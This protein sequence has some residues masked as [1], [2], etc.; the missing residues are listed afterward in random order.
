VDLIKS[1]PNFL[2]IGAAK[3]GT[4]SLFDLL[5]Q[6]PQIY[7]PFSK[8]PMYFSNDANFQRGP[9]W[10][11]RTFF[12]GA[13]GYPARG[14]ATPHY[15]YWSDKVAPRIKQFYRQ[16][17]IRFIVILRDPVAR[18]Y[19]WYWN[20]V[21]EGREDLPFKTA[22]ELENT[23]LHENDTKVRIPGSMTFGYAYGSCYSTLLQPFLNTFPRHDFHFLLQEDLNQNFQT[24]VSAIFE[25]LG[26]DAKFL[27][28]PVTSNPATLAR[29][30]RIQALL[31]GQSRARNILK[32]LIPLRLRYALVTRLLPL[33]ARPAEYPE[34]D[35]KMEA[36]LRLR[37]APEIHQLERIINRDL[38]TWLPG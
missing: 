4:T 29:S 23:R 26:V 22:L 37:F 6:H 19:S 38:S 3:A 9:E 21:K 11:A 16:T 15:L 28:S 13:A 27:S 5:K 33:N 31:H 1:L 20:M 12:K 25:F 2:I 14:E 36:D 35:A 30:H 24:T 18:A 8:E 34:L 7:L 17:E 10:Y 32:T